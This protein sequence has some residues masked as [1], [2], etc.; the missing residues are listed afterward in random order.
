MAGAAFREWLRHPLFWFVFVGASFF[1][2]VSPIIP[3]FTFGEDMKMVKEL[4]YD[5]LMLGGV[6]WIWGA[7]YLARDTANAPSML[8]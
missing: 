4:G 1:L 6:F 2:L 7:R 8:R 3:Y 5:W